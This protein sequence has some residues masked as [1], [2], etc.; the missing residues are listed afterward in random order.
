MAPVPD[1]LALECGF[2]SILK[3]SIKEKIMNKSFSNQYSIKNVSIYE[4]PQLDF[5]RE[6]FLRPEVYTMSFKKPGP[7]F[8]RRKGWKIKA[9]HR[10]VQK[11]IR[12][13]DAMI[14][15]SHPP[16]LEV[17][18]EQNLHQKFSKSVFS[19]FL[20]RRGRKSIELLSS[21]TSGTLLVIL[22]GLVKDNGIIKL[23]STQNR[24]HRFGG[25]KCYK[26]VREKLLLI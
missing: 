3:L 19:L 20:G 8:Q 6:P 1:L 17:W 24:K 26:D 14:I 18:T 2:N 13:M 4:L 9:K 7:G 12:T 15:S 10:M 23:P 11:C 21:L 5:C 25:I 16:P 22:M